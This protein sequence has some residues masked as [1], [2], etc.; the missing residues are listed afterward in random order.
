MTQ[1]RHAMARDIYCPRCGAFVAPKGMGRHKAACE[2][3]PGIESLEQAWN[4]GD[5][6]DDMARLFGVSTSTVEKWLIAAGLKECDR[7]DSGG[8]LDLVEDLALDFD[9]KCHDGC[10]DC[11]A[12][13]LCRKTVAVGFIF[14]EVPDSDQ[15]RNLAR[16][17]LDLPAIVRRAR[18]VFEGG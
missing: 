1:G 16:L 18:S 9:F 13:P 4:R 6:Q 8:I 17:G 5:T 12:F 11:I 7:R 2:K 10:R 14:C 3:Y 15:V